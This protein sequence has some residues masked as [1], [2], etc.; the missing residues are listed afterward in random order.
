[1][2]EPDLKAAKDK[3]R[4]QHIARATFIV[5]Q[6]YVYAGWYQYTLVP[7]YTVLIDII[8]D[9]QDVTFTVIIS[10]SCAGSFGISTSN[11]DD[12]LLAAK[13]NQKHLEPTSLHAAR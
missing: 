7:I 13:S 11:I 9:L 8:S 4:S 5:K 6:P 3:R 1:M 2:T 10:F 12:E